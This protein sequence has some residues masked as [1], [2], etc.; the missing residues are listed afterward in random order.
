MGVGRSDGGTGGPDRGEW[1][2]I[3]V[4]GRQQ[5]LLADATGVLAAAGDPGH[6]VAV[7]RY[8]RTDQPMFGVR[9]PA[10]RAAERTLADALPVDDHATYVADARP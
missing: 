2:P 6:A 7:Q 8:M 3:A 1:P 5:S 4:H 9:M 10:V